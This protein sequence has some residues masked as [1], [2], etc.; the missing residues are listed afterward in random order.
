M[1]AINGITTNDKTRVLEMNAVTAHRGPDASGCFA[2]DK[3]TLG[4]NRL[5]IIDTS[6][7]ANQPMFSPDRR[8]ALVF[9]GEIYNFKELRS[10]LRSRWDFK[11]NSDSEVLL[12]GYACWGEKVLSRLRGIFAFAL[13]DKESGELL[14]VR[15]Q[16]GVKPL[17]Y[18]TEDGNL[19]FSSEM[20]GIVRGLSKTASVSETA[21]AYYFSLNYIPSPE[22]LLKNV[23]KLRPGHLLKY[24]DGNI[25]LERYW[26]PKR[27]ADKKTKSGSSLYSTIDQVIK[28]Q[29]VADRPVGLLLSGGLDSSIVLHHASRYLEQVKTFSVDFEMLPGAEA[30]ESKFNSD[31]SLAK[32][33]A[34]IYGAEH[35]TF[36]LSLQEVAESFIDIVEKLDEP[37]ANAS[38]ISRFFLSKKVREVGV[39]VAF[40]GDGGDDLFGG[41]TRQKLAAVANYYQKLPGLARGLL[42]TSNANFRKLNTPFG[43]PMHMRLMALSGSQYAKL[44]KHR[45]ID[46]VV[47]D[48][49]NKRYKEAAVQGL[50][51]VDQFMRVDRESWLADESL[52]ETDRTSM[53]NGLEVRVPLLDLDLVNYSD[54]RYANEKFKP[55]STKHVL[56]QA[57][58]VHLPD[59]LFN[60]P[61]R[62]WLSPGAKWLRQPGVTKLAREVLSPGYYQGLEKYVD[63]N[64]VQILLDEHLEKRAYHLFPIWNLLILQIWARK[65]ELIL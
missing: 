18:A 56:R 17:Y 30:E 4:H 60:Q 51:A 63:W 54:L 22:T 61:K 11:T 52:A 59:Y 35:T 3:V 19:L 31:A 37:I 49:F 8:F 7:I 34:D 9:N 16:M 12:A 25:K 44:L 46:S 50:P 38:A 1:C 40:G 47:E 39:V 5:S 36:T 24:Q 53:A 6:E 21:L 29:L 62:G 15:D 41:Y 43:A 33:T 26:Q 13:W 32:R 55:W 27:P 20:A 48:F 64:E 14:L 23:Y 45:D 2:T 42:G 65:Q 10:E 28:R 57:Y 58:K